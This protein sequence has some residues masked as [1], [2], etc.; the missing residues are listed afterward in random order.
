[1]TEKSSLNDRILSRRTGPSG[2]DDADA[3]DD[4][5]AFGYLRGVRDRALMLDLRLKSGDREAFPYTL[6][7]RI[8]FDMSEGI[9]LQ[10]SG[11]SVKIVGRNLATLLPNGVVL[12]D[13]L[14]RHRVPWITEGDEL[15]AV[16]SAGDGVS[17]T[18]IQI[19][20]TR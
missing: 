10:F 5:G 12:L 13:G 1:V 19:T 8:R 15:R 17:V 14:Y 11:V 2:D 18:S 4:C 9:T 7:E 3:A 20:A 16:K 6:L